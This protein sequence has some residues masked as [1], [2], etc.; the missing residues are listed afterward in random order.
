MSYLHVTSSSTNLALRVFPDTSLARRDLVSVALNAQ[1]SLI[2]L[3]TSTNMPHH[4]CAQLALVTLLQ[5]PI[6][7]KQPSGIYFYNFNTAVELLNGARG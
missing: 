7:R 2:L 4:G 5:W 3:E 6:I 1:S